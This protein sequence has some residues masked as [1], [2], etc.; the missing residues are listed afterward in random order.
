MS[1]HFS[2]DWISAYL[3]GELS[4]Q[5]AAHVEDV[6]ARD[7]KQAR[8]FEEMVAMQKALRSQPTVS[9]PEQLR[10]NIMNAVAQKRALVDEPVATATDSTPSE[11][12]ERPLARMNDPKANW[13]IAV[14]LILAVSAMVFVPLLIMPRSGDRSSMAQAPADANRAEDTAFDLGQETDDEFG[15]MELGQ[16]ELA[17]ESPF[18]KSGELSRESKSEAIEGMR[19][20]PN[21]PGGVAN[22]FAG[23]IADDAGVGVNSGAGMNTEADGNDAK[24]AQPNIATDQQVNPNGNPRGGAGAG[25]GG[26]GERQGRSSPNRSIPFTGPMRSQANRRPT[27]QDGNPAATAGSSQRAAPGSSAGTEE[28]PVPNAPVGGRNEMR[29][30]PRAGGGGFGGSGA[31]SA[32]SGA[33]A[34]PDSG[35]A[36][37]DS[38]VANRF[39][40]APGSGGDGI[41]LNSFDRSS[42]GAAEIA[43]SR[44]A[45]EKD[46]EPGAGSEYRILLVVD[47]ESNAADSRRESRFTTRGSRVPL[48]AM[49]SQ[50]DQPTESSSGQTG[51][52]GRGSG[53]QGDQSQGGQSQ[54]NQSDQRS[55]Q[56]NSQG[57]GPAQPQRNQN[58]TEK[59]DAGEGNDEQLVPEQAQRMTIDSAT[60][61]LAELSDNQTQLGINSNLSQVVSPGFIDAY[62]F[63]LDQTEKPLETFSMSGS[64]LRRRNILP[65]PETAFPSADDSQGEDFEYEIT[66]ADLEGKSR[67]GMTSGLVMNRSLI[68][69]QSQTDSP[70][71]E[72]YEVTGSVEAVNGLIREMAA[73]GGNISVYSQQTNQLL[74]STMPDSDDD[75]VQQESEGSIP[76]LNLS[77]QSRLRMS[78]QPND[79]LQ[80]TLPNS[81]AGDA[82]ESANGADEATANENRS[83]IAANAEA[84]KQSIGPQDF[85]WVERS[86]LAELEKSVD[87]TG[88]NER[89]RNMESGVAEGNSGE[90]SGGGQDAQSTPE[91]APAEVQS[92]ESATRAIQLDNSIV[93]I[94]RLDRARSRGTTLEDGIG[95]SSER[96][97]EQNDRL[98]RGRDDQNLEKQNASQ[99]DAFS[100]PNSLANPG[101]RAN[102]NEQAA[103]DKNAQSRLTDMVPQIRREGR[104]RLTLVVRK[105]TPEASIAAN[106]D[107]NGLTGPTAEAMSVEGNLPAGNQLL[108]L[109]ESDVRAPAP[110]K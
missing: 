85:A 18:S 44:L 90:E 22:N 30:S 21:P 19:A 56:N 59:T 12:V 45:K 1:E 49:R 48:N 41:N 23:G 87:S 70:E 9:P 54:G 52:A 74:P 95:D 71:I 31:G 42:A 37:P 101:S 73:N 28:S 94:G 33:P 99:N 47:P 100:Q 110:R 93:P 27:Q 78:P 105:P 62:G 77:N 83:S 2:E 81:Q 26:G 35:M 53:D 46:V 13:R 17:E 92:S 34:S 64:Q 38:G 3:D 76:R 51:E 80:E 7:P 15:A 55:Q 58:Q 16:L 88:L 69:N 79:R 91:R 68:Q 98:Y 66:L 11:T 50:S 6:L 60:T 107:A 67:Q 61:N 24:A 75:S 25:F 4:E 102:P 97:A 32:G 86:R 43:A 10:Q 84:K 96:S 72:I 109:P 39:Q 63:R 5:E 57:S 20:F 14:G 104:V 106:S 89:L 103:S 40:A 108:R 8:V 65:I 29:I 82:A 36:S